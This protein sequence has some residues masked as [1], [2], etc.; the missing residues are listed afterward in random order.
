MASKRNKIEELLSKIQSAYSGNHFKSYIDYIRFPFYKNLEQDSKILFDFPITVLVGPNGSGKS[1]ALQGIYGMP[2][3][4]SPGHFWFSTSVDPIEDQGGAPCL[5]YGYRDENGNLKEVLKTRIGKKKGTHYWEPSRPLKRYNMQVLPNMARHPTVKKNVEYLDFRSELSAYDKFF[6]FSDFRITKTFKSK[7]DSIRIKSKHLRHTI[8]DN[9]QRTYYRKH[10]ISKPILLEHESL[11]WV[12]AILNK[13]YVECKL[14][15]HNLYSNVEGLTVYFRTDHHNYSEAFAGRGEFAVVKLVHQISQAPKY[16]LVLLDEPEV[17]LHPGA[18]EK[19]LEFLL[20]QTLEKKLQVVLST[21]SAKFVQFLPEKAIKLFYQTPNL[22]FA[23]KNSCHYVEAFENIGHDIEAR[24]KIFVEDYLAKGLVEEILKDMGKEYE[25]LFSV[26]FLPG[27]ADQLVTRAA[28]YSQEDGKDKFIL[29]DGDM[30]KISFN[31]NSMTLEEAGDFFAID[32]K[33]REVTGRDFKSLRFGLDS[34][35]TSGSL[36]KLDVAMK[37][38]QYFYY[39]V[40]YLPNGKIPEAIIWDHDF[41]IRFLETCKIDV[42]QFGIDEKENIKIFTE[43]FTGELSHETYKTCCK[44]FIN[45]FVRVKG[46]NYNEIKSTIEY[47][48][49]MIP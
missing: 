44:I 43:R 38:L 23:I 36:Q 5:I 20:V 2:E 41:A 11:K 37:F 21:H 46:Q 6:Y 26:S 10:K 32:A 19:L 31:P 33:I 3:G 27:G 24:A 1:S 40:K 25:L 29:L 48:K 42:P 17:S 12:N 49:S 45:E 13:E 16:S 22:R 30:T 15:N 28:M 34:S 7:Q 14:I 35:D 39:N 9:C 4:Y 18:Q 8:D 47:F